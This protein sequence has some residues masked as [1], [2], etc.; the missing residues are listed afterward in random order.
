[1]LDVKAILDDPAGFEAALRRRDPSISL[2]EIVQLGEERRRTVTRFGELRHQQRE[3]SA[4]MTSKDLSPADREALRAQLKDVSAE[5]KA[6]ELRAKEL[7]DAADAA[8]LLIPNPPAPEAPDGRGAEDNVV[9]R[10]WG[11]PRE[12]A[13]E[14]VEHDTLGERLGVLDFEAARKVSG[15]RFVLYR[16]LGARLERALASFMLDLHT[17]THGYEEVLPPYLVL[18]ESMVGTNQLPKFEEDA[19]VTAP[20]GLFL[21]PTAEVPVTNMH[22]EEILDVER[23]PIKYAAYSSCF[24]REAGSHGRDT[25]GLTRLH[26]FQKVELVQFATPEGSAAAHEALVGH[27]E[28]V[29]QLLNLPYRVVDLCA[30]DMGF[31]ARRCYDLEVWLPAQKM[32][33]EIS[34]C[35]NFGDFQARR[36]G[37]RYRP[38]V[39]EKPRFVHTINGSGLAIG[40]TVMAILENYQREDGSVDVPE[41]LWPFMGT[42]RIEARQ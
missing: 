6:L 24:R 20:D 11:Q 12:F 31:G 38:A 26:Q 15:A 42:K 17:G 35:S 34:S 19:F 1:V 37:I 4:Q 39:G 21:I 27:A 5:V 30:G 10:T 13:W 7:E 9:V 16:G 41:V 18:R 23:L 25:R 29:L 36:A 14:L 33:R 32:W 8:A 2:A 28:R 40:R 3:A 22:R